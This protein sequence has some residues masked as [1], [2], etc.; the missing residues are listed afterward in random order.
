MKRMKAFLA[1]ILGTYYYLL[2]SYLR[3]GLDL[4]DCDFIILKQTD[5][6]LL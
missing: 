5:C 4:V 1:R 2:F 6:F 3:G